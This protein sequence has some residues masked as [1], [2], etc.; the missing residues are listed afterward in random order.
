MVF[1]GADTIEGNAAARDAG[2]TD[3]AEMEYVGSGD[4]LNIF[5]QVHG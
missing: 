4:Y 1:M 2:K 3:L 5:A